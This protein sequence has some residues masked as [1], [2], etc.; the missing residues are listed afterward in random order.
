MRGKKLLSLCLGAAFCLAAVSGCTG[1]P[2]KK[3]DD[4]G[5]NPPAVVD[6]RVEIMGDTD[7]STGIHLL[8]TD[9]GEDGRT[10]YRKLTW[11]GTAEET[12]TPV[13]VMAQWCSKYD[14]SDELDAGRTVEQ[15]EGD[16]YIYEDP[17]KTLRFN[18]ET[19]AIDLKIGRAHV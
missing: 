12:E 14:M 1:D 8:G 7:F 18:A 9:A 11:G 19:K 15:K 16:T 2:E 17:S 6:D 5:K 13:W 4:E 10:T 3:P